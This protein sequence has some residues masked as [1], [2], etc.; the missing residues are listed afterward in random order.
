MYSWFDEELKEMY[1]I[2]ILDYPF[3][4]EKGYSIIS[5]NGIK[6]LIIKVERLSQMAEVIGEF[7]GNQKIELSNKNVGCDKEYAHIYKEI[8]GKIRIP[9]EY[10]EHYYK[11][12]PY[13]NHFY[14][15]DERRAFWDKWKGCI[16]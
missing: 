14:S 12:N 10:V 13:T 1:G 7:L 9:K 4:R 11:N 6:I 2:D 8:K 15:K 16:K 5:E 3:D